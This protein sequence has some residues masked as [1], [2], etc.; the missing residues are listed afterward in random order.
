MGVPLAIV[1]FRI[2][3]YEKN[4]TCQFLH[5]ADKTRSNVLYNILQKW[6]QIALYQKRS[7]SK[8]NTLFSL[9]KRSAKRTI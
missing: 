6:E 4:T 3:E 1:S 9:S 5:T 8:L 7:V 2:I